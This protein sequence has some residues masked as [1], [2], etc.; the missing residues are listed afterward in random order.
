[1]VARQAQ[2][3]QR[4]RERGGEIWGKKRTRTDSLIVS[5]N[6]P[7]NEE[8]AE[9]S[10]KVR[11]IKAIR[12][13]VACARNAKRNCDAISFPKRGPSSGSWKMA[14]PGSFFLKPVILHEFG[15]VI[16]LGH[17]SPTDGSR[18]VM[19]PYYVANRL[20]LSSQDKERA[21]ALYEM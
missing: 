18:D 10:V 6:W 17:S 1:M 11:F 12:R 16:G 15:H 20:K 3:I 9:T 21:K 5:N 19:D 8:N 4:R 7:W 14:Q 2:A 13:C